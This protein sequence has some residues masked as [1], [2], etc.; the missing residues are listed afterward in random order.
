MS[1]RMTMA[2]SSRP[3]AMIL[4]APAPSSDKPVRRTVF[5]SPF[6]NETG[7]EQYDPAAAGL[8]DL[9]AV[10]LAEQPNLRVVE[11]QR[12]DALTDEQARSLKGLTG[13]PYA[14]AAGKLFKADTVLVGRLFLVDG[15]MTVSAK[16]IDLASDRV[17]ASDQASG[18]PED[19]LDVSLQLAGK[20]ARQMDLPLPKIDPAAIDASPVAGLHFAKAL[21]HYYAGNMDEAVMQFMRTIDL[22]PNYTEVHY[23]SALCYEKAGEASHAV[24]DFESYLKEHPQGKYAQD[25]AQR[26]AAAKQKA[27]GE[28]VPHLVPPDKPGTSQPA[29]K[30][31][32]A[33]ATAQ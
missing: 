17:L 22:D 11:R 24:I 19:V 13:E 26:L 23:W 29:R 7:Q 28:A 18:R 27:A 1:A 33:G 10:L 25:A 21:S 16:A 3:L 32:A 15:K 8:G 20:L 12:L 30:A 5:A 2:R 9:V 31:P 6:G 4:N 14:V